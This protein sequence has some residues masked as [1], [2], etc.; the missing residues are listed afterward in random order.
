MV[1]IFVGHLLG[2][3]SAHMSEQTNYGMMRFFRCLGG[4]RIIYFGTM[5]G[6]QAQGLPECRI[7]PSAVL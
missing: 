5:A 6:T 2:H 3:V 4:Q 7:L 1:E